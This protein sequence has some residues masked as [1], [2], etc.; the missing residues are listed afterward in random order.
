MLDEAREQVGPALVTRSE[1]SRRERVLLRLAV[2][3]AADRLYVSYPRLD[4]A[5]GRARVPSFYAL[6]VLR[7]A[8]GTIPD[9]QRL[10]REAADTG[11]RTLA[12]PAP[13]RPDDA[14]D[15]QE[16]DLSVLRT[17]L[18]AADPASVRGHAQYLL[19]FE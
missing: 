1:R 19:R 14:I 15:A 9:L 12:W 11:D 16:H 10:T 8:T 2:G 18:D 13:Q 4:V 7:G 3:A 6:D 5:E 17:L